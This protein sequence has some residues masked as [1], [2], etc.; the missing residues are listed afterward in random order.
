[1]GSYEARKING[2]LLNLLAAMSRINIERSRVHFTLYLFHEMSTKIDKHYK[3]MFLSGIN[4]LRY[5]QS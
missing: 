3:Y 2:E 5:V 4:E 1:M